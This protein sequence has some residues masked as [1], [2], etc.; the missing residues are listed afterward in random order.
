MIAEQEEPKSLLLHKILSQ[1]FR[2]TQGKAF[3]R[4]FVIVQHQIYHAP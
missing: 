3:T 2:N 1:G 4:P